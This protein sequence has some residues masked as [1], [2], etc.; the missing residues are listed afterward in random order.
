MSLTD[1]DLLCYRDLAV[2]QTPLA[3]PKR[4][5]D[6]YLQRTTFSGLSLV[7]VGE[8]GLSA[9]FPLRKQC[10]NQDAGIVNNPKRWGFAGPDDI[11]GAYCA[12][13]STFFS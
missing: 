2:S 10:W 3:E 11:I 8:S 12:S 6:V 5:M 13:V 9:C 7:L 4:C 1:M